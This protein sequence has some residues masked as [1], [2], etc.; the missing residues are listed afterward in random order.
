MAKLLIVED[1]KE[2]AD[3]L[4]DWLA[5]EKHTIE[6][7]DNGPEALDRLKLYSYD[8]IIL[9][10]QIPGLDGLNVCREYRNRGGS[11]PVLILT[12][13]E[14][15]PQA[16]SI[17]LDTGADDYMIKPFHPSELSA[18]IRALLRRS[19]GE[20]KTI[21]KAGDLTLDP[22]KHSLTKNGVEIHLGPREFELLHFL[23]R[24]CNQVFS[25]E[26]I[27]DRVWTSESDCSPDAVRV[28]IANL[29]R[30]IDTSGHRSFIRTIHR[31]GYVFE[32]QNSQ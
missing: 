18:R 21:L 25:A 16:K 31:V 29:R 12:G 4:K 30:K 17:G 23:M 28:Y 3:S 2:A 10:L 8:V 27:L 6:V 5:G 15:T 19:T 9:D 26:T 20:A 24:H 13:K 14:L 7:V 1:E 32:S 22:K 11:T